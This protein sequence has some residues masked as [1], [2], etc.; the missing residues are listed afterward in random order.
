MQPE[1]LKKKIN[2]QVAFIEYL[3]LEN[4]QL[5]NLPFELLKIKSTLLI[6]EI[7]YDINNLDIENKILIFKRNMVK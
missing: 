6:D 7:S 2:F 5:K 1:N 3:I 4:N